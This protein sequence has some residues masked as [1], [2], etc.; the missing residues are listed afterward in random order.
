V[1]QRAEQ[2]SREFANKA[3]RI[4]RDFC[5]LFFR[6]RMRDSDI[7]AHIHF[8]HEANEVAALNEAIAPM[9]EHIRAVA[10]HGEPAAMRHILGGEY[11]RA[12]HARA[13]ISMLLRAT[14]HARANLS[15]YFPILR[16][17]V[18]VQAQALEDAV[19]NYRATFE[20]LKERTL[21]TH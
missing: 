4:S 11:F 1:G 13:M 21:P 5:I 2:T 18:L 6:R 17:D 20:A 15:D 14:K 16:A 3:L 9:M 19:T 10:R 7:H 8:Q 12:M